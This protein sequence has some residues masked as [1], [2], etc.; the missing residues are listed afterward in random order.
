MSTQTLRKPRRINGCSIAIASAGAIA[1][2]GGI[3]AP[4]LIKNRSAEPISKEFP[5]GVL[6]MGGAPG[7][8]AA[9]AP[10]L[11]RRGHGVIGRKNR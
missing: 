4:I 7:I 11:V 9:I 5:V 2:L 3:A 1:L 8:L 6:V 10:G